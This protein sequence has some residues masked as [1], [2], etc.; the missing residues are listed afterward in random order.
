MCLYEDSL[1][2]EC[3]RLQL[4]VFNHDNLSSGAQEIPGYIYIITS[5]ASKISY[6]GETF[7]IKEANFYKTAKTCV[8]L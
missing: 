8:I 1:I 4:T 7:N 6:N 3:R 5:V 2:E